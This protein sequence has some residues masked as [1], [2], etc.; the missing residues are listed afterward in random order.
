VAPAIGLGFG[1]GRLHHLFSSRAREN[2][3]LSAFDAGIRHF[4]VAPPYGD[5]MAETELG[6]VLRSKRDQISIATK[7]GIPCS[8]WG[9]RNRVVYYTRTAVSRATTRLFGAKRARREFAAKSALTSLHDSL[10]RLRTDHVDYFFIHEPLDSEQYARAAE[11]IDTLED[12]RR[13]GLIRHYGVAAPTALFI[14]GTARQCIGDATQF[15]IGSNSEKLLASLPPGHKAFAYGLVR[16]CKAT[17]S[18]DR[19]DL[20]AILHWFFL[21]FPDVVPL[22]GT[23][24]VAQLETLRRSLA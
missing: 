10:R 2:L 5:G 6:R 17:V 4:D 22:I 13:G 3:L 19:I 24:R 1:L 21:N 11:L 12:L 7:F 16:Y 18:Q 8:N 20:G 23:T 14:D 15:E 9:E